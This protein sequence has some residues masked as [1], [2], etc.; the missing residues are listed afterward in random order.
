MPFVDFID[1]DHALGRALTET[2]KATGA[3]VRHHTR[4]EYHPDPAELAAVY[5]FP[6]PSQTNHPIL[7]AVHA[8]AP[9]TPVVTVISDEVFGRPEVSPQQEWTPTVPRSFA[10]VREMSDWRTADVF[11]ET[12]GHSCPVAIVYPYVD[13]S[14][15]ADLLGVLR[16]GVHEDRATHV[17]VDDLDSPR[18]WLLVSEAATA[19]YRIAQLAFRKPSLN[20]D[21]FL[22]RDTFLIG[23]GYAHSVAQ[24]LQFLADAA[25]RSCV[26]EGLTIT[27][28]DQAPFTVSGQTG[29][30]NQDAPYR[31]RMANPRKMLVEFDWLPTHKLDKI[32]AAYQTS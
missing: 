22:A 15:P 5:V 1:A 4:S 31:Q 18:D 21:I 11:A 30:W 20:P 28:G 14:D 26:R 29:G 2:W 13:P 17:T 8:V 16:A 32:L 3:T 24:V 6:H 9:A 19:L 12:T 27:I 7:K 10:G 25:G 23:T